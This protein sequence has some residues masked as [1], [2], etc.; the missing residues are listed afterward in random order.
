MQVYKKLRGIIEESIKNNKKCIS[1][2]YTENKKCGI[3][4]NVINVRLPLKGQGKQGGLALM[5]K[6]Y[7]VFVLDILWVTDD[8]VRCSNT[9]G[10]GD[11]TKEDIFD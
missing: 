6:N 10:K 8:A 3:M 2:D 9:Y 7:E 1:F 4:Y 11:D 5:K